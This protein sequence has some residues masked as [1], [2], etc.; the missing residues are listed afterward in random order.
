M[1]NL[2]AAAVL[3][4]LALISLTYRVSLGLSATRSLFAATISQMHRERGVMSE[5]SLRRRELVACCITLGIDFS[6]T[7][8]LSGVNLY[9]FLRTVSAAA[10]H[11]MSIS[12]MMYD[13]L[14]IFVISINGKL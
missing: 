10:T 7:C 6:S 3:T 1:T 2:I 4:G 14:M 9:A 11:R 8:L 12:E 13:D 5:V